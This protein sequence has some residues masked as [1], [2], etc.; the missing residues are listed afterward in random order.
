MKNK[1][2]HSRNKNVFE[3][4]TNQ[5]QKLNFVMEKAITK[6]YTIDCS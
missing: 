4:G 3:K 1:Q 5:P 2:V 6:I